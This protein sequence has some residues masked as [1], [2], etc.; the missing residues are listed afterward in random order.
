MTVA[1]VVMA[2]GQSRRMGFDKL[3]L[4]YQGVD[5][6]SWAARRLH[7]CCDRVVISGNTCNIVGM[8]CDT[9][10]DN[11]PGL[12]PLGGLSSVMHAVVADRYL[13]LAADLPMVPLSL[14]ETLA[15]HSTHAAIVPRGGT[16]M[17]EPLCA[18]YPR[19]ALP[20]LDR[21]LS[22]GERSFHALFRQVPVVFFDYALHGFDP[23]CFLNLNSP[24][25]L[26]AFIELSNDDPDGNGPD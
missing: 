17:L 24:A 23:A 12:G 7:D 20:Q 26:K 9:V 2:G 5:L 6:V 16:E 13:V 18:C 10:P 25:D 21:L 1:G 3:A 19:T 14:L 15:F 4:R 22:E 8:A 11:I